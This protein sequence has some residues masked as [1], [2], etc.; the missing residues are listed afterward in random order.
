MADTLRR[1]LF[2]QAASVVSHGD[3][4][5]RTAH[6]GRQMVG[7]NDDG[8]GREDTVYDRVE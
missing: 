2:G 7:G 4:Q 5:C 3:V 8:P 1:M 6:I